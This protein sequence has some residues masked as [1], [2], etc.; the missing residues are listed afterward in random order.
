MI[1]I[2]DFPKHA[3]EPALPREL[4]LTW[5]I[6]VVMLEQSAFLELFQVTALLSFLESPTLTLLVLLIPAPDDAIG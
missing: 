1:L 6:R 4:V 2:A 3:I 5:P